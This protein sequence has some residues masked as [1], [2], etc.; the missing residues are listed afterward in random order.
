MASISS[1][2]VYQQALILLQH[3]SNISSDEIRETVISIS[4]FQRS[5]DPDSDHVVDVDAVVRQLESDLSVWVDRPVTLTDPKGHEE[6]LSARRGE[7]NWNFWD[8]YRRY[9]QTV[10]TFPPETLRKLDEITDEIMRHLEDPRRSG[11]WDRRGMVVGQVQSGKTANYTGLICKAVDAGY[12][13]IVVL[14]GSH[15][16]LRSQTQLRLDEGFLGYDTQ[17]GRSVDQSDIRIGAGAMPGSQNLIVQSVTSS[18]D[19]GDFNLRVA[20]SVNNMFGGDPFLL[21]IKKNQS[22]LKNVIKWATSIQKT[23]DPSTGNPIVEN[24]PL[25]VIDDEADNASINTK[26][27][28]LGPDGKPDPDYDPSRINGQIRL[29]L[30]SFGQSA[31]IGYTATPFANIFIA[32]E[33]TNQVSK[34]G[35][36]LFPRSFIVNLPA[37]SNYMGPV[38]VF[39]LRETGIDGLEQQRGMP[40]VRSVADYE[41]WI[42]DRHKSGHRPH[43]SDMPDSLKY[44]M[45]SFVLACAARMARGQGTEHNSMLV[46]VTRFN[47][48]QQYVAEQIRDELARIRDSVRYGD[49]GASESLLDELSALWREDF[50]PTSKLIQSASGPVT[51]WSDIQEVLRDS[52]EKIEVRVINGLAGDALTYYEHRKDGLSVIVVGGDKLS[53]GLTLEGLTVSYYLRASKM[54]DTLMQ[55]GRWF[56]YRPGY[57]DLC[58]LYT[59]DELQGWYQDIT[60]ASEELRREFDFM[61][62]Q[63]AT[64]AD[65]GLRVRSHPDGLM[66]TAAAK[67]R[68]AE[69]VKVSFS[70]TINETVN[71][72]LEHDV[73]VN[74]AK[75]TM[76]LL[77]SLQSTGCATP[78]PGGNGWVWHTDDADDIRD[79]FAAYRTHDQAR[80]VHSDV[81]AAYIEQRV[82]HGEL[83]NWTIV[84]SGGSESRTWPVATP[85]RL[86]RREQKLDSAEH[87]RIGRLVSPPDE[88]LDLTPHLRQRAIALTPAS[89]SKSPLFPSGEAVRNVRPPTDGL[90]LLYPL[91]NPRNDDDT[92]I[93]GFAVSFPFSKSPLASIDYKVNNIYYQQEFGDL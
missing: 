30:K 86:V 38:R 64:P 9:L 33:D 35:E 39:G 59:T 65:Y 47:A 21:V 67:M 5:L 80:K 68:D 77:N 89:D 20:K 74:N 2:T 91:A 15:N 12:K 32:S 6:W 18:L 69:T 85:V 42:P 25:L 75:A 4:E 87:Y 84:L 27:T 53:R 57:E 71:F 26:A 44:A 41:A 93:V 29:L 66:V 40:I 36:D 31:Y 24:V 13:L 10:K 73:V 14:A 82:R 70:G 56:G 17:K 88:A 48:V 1:S 90:L 78:L 22:V 92:P 34:F 43:V 37:P 54:Y 76:L 60:V 58:R 3:R 52:T 28:V 45:K 63:N 55:M 62:S 50:E 19:K 16:S 83:T 51:T 46:H 79:F 72:S 23:T 7:I 61:A 8:R 11:R 49:G 81:L